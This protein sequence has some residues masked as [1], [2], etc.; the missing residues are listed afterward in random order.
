MWDSI[1]KWDIKSLRTQLCIIQLLGHL[2]LT[3]VSSWLKNNKTILLIALWI[4]WPMYQKMW[5]N[6]LL[7]LESTLLKVITDQFYDFLFLIT[8]R[9]ITSIMYYAR[10]RH[11]NYFLYQKKNF[12][13]W[14]ISLKLYKM[15]KPT[16]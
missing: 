12:N 13:L 1:Q 6:D 2:C 9:F 11:P 14:T 3:Q 16:S 7:I 15:F 5:M 8:A 10:L 4:L